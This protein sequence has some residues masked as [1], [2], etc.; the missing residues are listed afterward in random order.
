MTAQGLLTILEPMHPAVL[1]ACFYFE[2]VSYDFMMVSDFQKKSVSIQRF[3]LK[4]TSIPVD[5]TLV[6]G[7]LEW[8]ICYGNFV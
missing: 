1:D 3:S 7:Y 4:L 5:G 2:N 6:M 8:C